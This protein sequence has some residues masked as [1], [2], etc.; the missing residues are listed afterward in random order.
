[1][2]QWENMLSHGDSK[3]KVTSGAAPHLDLPLLL[4]LFSRPRKHM[5]DF[6]WSLK[7]P[8]PTTAPEVH[9]AL[10]Q[11]LSYWAAGFEG[12]KSIQRVQTATSPRHRDWGQATV[13]VTS[14]LMALKNIGLEWKEKALMAKKPLALETKKKIHI[15]LRHG[16]SNVVVTLGLIL[17]PLNKCDSIK[18]Q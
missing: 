2:G 5:E 8:N 12:W 6:G 9:C 3:F 4:G 17:F 7:Y 15:Y 18:W 11:W 10:G 1:M 16:V 14:D 13:T